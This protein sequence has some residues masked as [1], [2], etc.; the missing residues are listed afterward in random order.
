MYTNSTK[1]EASEEAQNTIWHRVPVRWTAKS[2]SICLGA[3]CQKA[4]PSTLRVNMKAEHLNRSLEGTPVANQHEQLANLRLFLQNN[5]NA[6]LLK[7]V[8]Q[9]TNE[10]LQC[11]F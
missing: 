9:R 4:R 10:G 6:F 8:L 2:K 3:P 7:V 11:H 1:P 5:V